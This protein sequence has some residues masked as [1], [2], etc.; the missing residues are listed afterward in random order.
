MGFDGKVEDEN[1]DRI[2]DLIL[3]YINEVSL[4]STKCIGESR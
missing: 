2:C 1:D 4:K 3:N